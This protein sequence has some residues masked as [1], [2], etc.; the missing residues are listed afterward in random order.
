MGKV[1]KDKRDIYYRQAKEDGYRARSAYKLLQL[2]EEFHFFK[3]VTK[4]VD[5]CAAPGSWSQVCCEKLAKN[6]NHP[7]CKEYEM[8]K[9]IKIVAVDL[10]PIAPYPPVIRIQGDITEESTATKI[11]ESAE[12]KVDL[13]ICDGAPDV[14][15]LHAFDEFLQSQLV[16]SALNITTM[17]LKEGGHFVAKIFRAKN[18]QLLQTQMEMFFKKVEV[19][20]PKS[21]R[22]SSSESFIVCMDYTPIPDYVPTLK[23]PMFLSDYDKEITKLTGINRK[24]VPFLSCGDTSGWDSDKT[25]KLPE[26]KKQSGLHDPLGIFGDSKYSSKNPVEAPINPNYLTSVSLKKGDRLEKAEPSKIEVYK[27]V[28]SKIRLIAGDL[29]KVVPPT[30]VSNPT[31]V[32]TLAE[33]FD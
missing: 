6:A 9:E 30:S 7:V 4:V 13:V 31:S 3:Y 12:G 32:D 27:S 25:N 24:I 2:D 5:L 20:K 19:A 28:L 33:L 21:S 16:L 26:L 18:V 29:E 1:S 15:G 17:I 14:T 11:I 22:Q 8:D 10:Q 23:N